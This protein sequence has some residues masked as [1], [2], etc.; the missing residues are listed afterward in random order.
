MTQIHLTRET[1][2]WRIGKYLSGRKRCTRLVSCCTEKR[3]GETSFGAIYT[4]KIYIGEKR[5]TTRKKRLPYII[6][7]NKLSQPCFAIFRC[8]V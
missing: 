5:M 3:K 7:N 1:Y 2:I 4:Y 6:I 8:D